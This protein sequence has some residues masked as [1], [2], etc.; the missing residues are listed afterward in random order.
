MKNEFQ[1]RYQVLNANQRLAVDAIDGP[2]MVIAG[3]GTGKTELL[4]VRA[5]N[6][7]AG[8]DTL[9]S[10][11]LCLTFTDSAAANMRERLIG[12]IGP[13]AYKIAIHTFH[14]F[15]TEIMN[16]YAQYF[17]HGAHFRPADELSTHEILS[18]LLAKLPHD[19]PLAVTMNGEFTY[20]SDVQR[21]I[22]EMKRSSY[23]PDEINAI[24]DRNDAFCEWVAPKLQ[25]AF[26]PTLSKK[27]FPSISTL[28]TEIES[29]R[30]QPLDLIGYTPLC[31]IIVNSLHRAYDEATDENST[32]PLS[33]WKRQFLYKNESGEQALR[34]QKHSQKLRLTAQL[35][36]EYLLAMQEREL[37]DYDDMILRVVHAME[38][39]DELRYELQ[40]QYQYI[41]VDEFQDTNEAQMRLVWNLTNNPSSEGRP[42]I[43]VVGDDDQAIYR[44]QGA[45]ISNV[46]DFVNTYRDV[47]I[48]TLTDNYRSTSD[49]LAA[50]HATAEQI[51]ERLVTRLD[52]ID[53][54]LA[55]H[56][57]VKSTP[58][59][60][61]QLPTE[62]DARHYLAT[63]LLEAYKRDATVSRAVIARNHRHLLALLPHLEAAGVPLRYEFQENILET[64]PVQQ[65]ELIARVL[66]H[67]SQSEFDD[68]NAL[69]PELL[70]H[71]AWQIAPVEL[72]RLSLDAQKNRRYWLEEML[73][74][75]GRLQDVAEWLI[76]M[77]H[78]SLNEPLETMIDLMWGEADAQAADSSQQDDQ[79]E[80][81]DVTEDV[82]APYRAFFFPS[83]SLETHPTQYLTWLHSLQQLRRALR[84][85][86][87]DHDLRLID[88]V[89]YL[90]MYHDSGLR[91]Q[92]ST[93]I[94]HDESA[95]T[96]L[97]AHKSKGLEFDE[98][99]LVDAIEQVW[100]DGA[101]AR[102]R[103]IHF[104]SNMPLAPAGDSHDERVRLLYVAMTRARNVLRCIGYEALDSGKPTLPIAALSSAQLP[105]TMPDIGAVETI[106]ALRD[107]WQTRTLDVAL[108]TKE[109]LLTP[110]LEQYRLSATHLNNFLNIPA[111][112][113]ELFLLHNLLRFPL[114]MSPHAAY[115]SAIHAALQRAHAHLSA[116]GNRRPIEDVLSDFEKNLA[117][118]ALSE[119][120]MQHFAARGSQSLTAFLTAAYDSFSPSQIVERSFGGEQVMVGD[121]RISGAIDLI[122]IDEQEKTIFI[123]DYKT[124]KP[125]RSW[126][127]KTDYE[128]IKLHHYEQ[129]LMMYYLL[130]SGSSQFAGYTITGGQIAYVEPSANGDIIHLDYTYD[131]VKLSE[132]R[133]LLQAV[134]RR[135]MKLDFT[136]PVDYEPT[137]KGILEFEQDSIK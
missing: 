83:E 57:R 4:S 80:P 67:L 70:A 108:A 78:R 123:T 118:H 95:I 26:A 34:D 60:M 91:L 24:L 92:A 51:D 2:V 33:A 104:P 82:V 19:N 116:T 99:Y 71:P 9:P 28:I 13:E 107:D 102:S 58:P 130:I 110:L 73:E 68:V 132:F 64:E 97:T 16:R 120:D 50:A 131:E 96:L 40:E 8:T 62:T 137:Y 119:Q 55:A 18:E 43:M 37:Y 11:I 22:S 17:Y 103:L 56:H 75:G 115:G 48:V 136:V 41:M 59:A 113:P 105:V 76:V 85:Y 117:E 84:D 129:Q 30:D 69:L 15:G 90:D 114:A 46:L 38:V 3:P 14:S 94:D 101:R 42:N 127:G 45:D 106:E 61:I 29:Y 89:R 66:V 125:T 100:G 12:L 32:K 133:R 98:A 23:T 109:R 35:Y 5:A 121:A 39:F 10:S 6:I 1:K 112:G 93:A 135:I 81:A 52:G 77:A 122:D 20:L 63:E 124:G 111:G 44:F 134:W 7:L 88:F 36:Y 53:K 65:L 79:N 54:A 31:D 72:W 74:S 86:H 87:T 126:Q 27:Q 21:V 47:R 25:P 49:I 128:K